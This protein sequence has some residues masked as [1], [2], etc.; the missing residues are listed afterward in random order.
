[1]SNSTYI[2]FKLFSNLLDWVDTLSRDEL[3]RCSLWWIVTST[4]P[5]LLK[6]NEKLY[7][8]ACRLGGEVIKLKQTPRS[9]HQSTLDQLWRYARPYNSQR[10]KS[11]SYWLFILEEPRDEIYRELAVSLRMGGQLVTCSL[12]TNNFD[13]EGEGGG[14]TEYRAVWSAGPDADALAGRS[15]LGLRS[16]GIYEKEFFSAALPP[17]WSPPILPEACWPLDRQIITYE[18]LDELEHSLCSLEVINHGPHLIDLVQWGLPHLQRIRSQ[19]QSSLE[20]EET[21]SLRVEERPPAESLPPSLREF[22]KP[23]FV[24]RF[25]SKVDQFSTLLVQAINQLEGRGFY[26]LLYAA[27]DWDE[28][29]EGPERW[30]FLYAERMTVDHL[31][32]WSLIDRYELNETLDRY[33]LPNV[34]IDSSS[35][36][37][38]PLEMM[39]DSSSQ[40]SIDNLKELLHEPNADHLTLLEYSEENTE[41]PIITKINLKEMRSFAEVV[42]KLTEGWNSA[43][44]QRASAELAK[45]DSVSKWQRETEQTL[46]DIASFEHE[47]LSET[48]EE[49]LCI[50]KE[51]GQR[52]IDAMSA[53]SEPVIMSTAI[54]EELTRRITDSDHNYG[55]VCESLAEVSQRLTQPRR[56]WISEQTVQRAEALDISRPLVSE[57]ESVRETAEDIVNA[58]SD[59]SDA[60]SRGSSAIAD[61]RER[62]LAQ[63][64][65]A[66]QSAEDARG[67]LEELTAASR[68]ASKR[69]SRANEETNT[70]MREAQ[71]VHQ[72]VLA[73]QAVLERERRAIESLVTQNESINAENDRDEA[74]YT[75][76]RAEAESK[77]DRL[78]NVRDV[79]IPRL[80]HEAEEMAQEV[81][82]LKPKRIEREH[83]LESTKR[84]EVFDKLNEVKRKRAET[85]ALIAETESLNESLSSEQA[86]RQG[87]VESQ[88]E[89]RRQLIEGN[90]RLRELER[91]LNKHRLKNREMQKRGLSD[92][93]FRYRNSMINLCEE[94]FRRPS[95][96]RDR[97]I[98]MLAGDRAKK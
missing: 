48:N 25:K 41:I 92:K 69:I 55:K 23:S 57:M 87:E 21:F 20:S 95:T 24:F 12:K 62:W 17:G 7:K 18:G 76:L 70:R 31:N 28:S 42:V 45:P 58:L 63:Q 36:V 19:D 84:Q 29:Y 68:E 8:R 13:S 53:A 22:D 86:A 75:K 4:Y 82:R 47:A 66:E 83:T 33:G 96:W 39:I 64:T 80:K 3:K 78:I 94:S 38:P 40:Q 15:L 2:G 14:Y 5:Y 65:V 60:L 56:R 11:P 91:K 71:V 26:E 85:L 27:I 72:Q 43:T 61:Q 1:M 98:L 73:R 59:R 16:L 49:A 37:S 9:T 6:C 50:L 34:Y 32:A 74:T 90:E 81:Q 77:R 10:V 93:E 97:M 46:A 54:A 52:A 89:L 67:Q 51:E 88:K 30:H 79:V 35:I 44:L